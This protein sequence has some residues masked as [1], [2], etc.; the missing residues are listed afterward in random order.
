M[1]RKTALVTGVTGQDGAYLSA[2]LLEHGY[3]VIGTFSSNR[4]NFWRLEE[5]EIRNHPNIELRAHELTDGQANSALIR[6][7]QPNEIYNLASVS[8]LAEANRDPLLT[9]ALNGFAPVSMLEAI[10]QTTP[11]T[12]FFQASSAEMFGLNRE[13]TQS[14]DTPLMPVGPYAATKAYAHQMV[15]FYRKHYDVFACSG[16][17]YNHESPL[18]GSNFVTQKI[19]WGLQDV[20]S[21]KQSHIEVGNLDAVRDWGYAGDYVAAMHKMLTATTADDYLLCTGTL[22]SVREFIELSGQVIGLK[23]KWRHQGLD[24]IGINSADDSTIIRVNQKYYRTENPLIRTGTY[25]RALEKLGWR[26]ETSIKE[27]CRLMM[28]AE[29]QPGLL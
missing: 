15:Q 29:R 28:S 6:E 11:G 22:T 23:I 13:H 1:A 19:V 10:R 17:L 21:G 8:S 26:P 9:G 18:R 24:E 16:I 12:R 2:R 4:T 3:R 27:I 7:L 20:V 5:L 25:T 14:E